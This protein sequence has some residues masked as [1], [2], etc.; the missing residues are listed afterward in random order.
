MNSNTDRVV[1]RKPPEKNGALSEKNTE[2]SAQQALT[3]DRGEIL[4]LD[5]DAIEVDQKFNARGPVDEKDKAFQALAG[6]IKERGLIENLEV[7]KLKKPNNKGQVYGLV[8]GF[9]RHPACRTAGVSRVVCLV[10]DIDESDAM[11]D[12]LAENEHREGLRPYELAARCALLKKDYG[13][14]GDQIGQKLH[15]SKS[16]VNNLIRCIEKLP[17][18]I[19]EAFR[20]AGP[21]DALKVMDYVRLSGLDSKNEMME[22]WRTIQGKLQRPTE[23]GPARKKRGD[24]DKPMRVKSRDKL[25]LLMHHLR[26]GEDVWIDNEWKTMS[27]RD[28]AV[29]RSVIRW[30]I[31]D[32]QRYPVTL[33]QEEIEEHDG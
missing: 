15:K 33:P 9:R 23:D 31:G 11:L 4:I 21:D 24:E 8:A 29:A 17:T 7:R 1:T 6:D 20:R 30:A 13:L 25:T 32:V 12:N 28:R 10:K 5:L 3:T 14:T 19:L 18:P 16:H 22:M 2:S 26:D 27:D